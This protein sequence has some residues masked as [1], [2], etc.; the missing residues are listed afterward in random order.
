VQKGL[1]AARI[2]LEGGPPRP[3]N[4]TINLRHKSMVTFL[5][6][7]DGDLFGYLL[8]SQLVTKLFSRTS[9]L[10]AKPELLGIVARCRKPGD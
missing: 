2:V 9:P 7:K 4:V 10:A 6:G 3:S 5:L 8:R 1:T